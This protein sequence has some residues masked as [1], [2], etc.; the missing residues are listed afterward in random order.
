V[1]LAK[2]RFGVSWQVNRAGLEDLL[3][4]G[5]PQRA[6]RATEACTA[7]VIWT[8]LRPPSSGRRARG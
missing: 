4:E 3:D 8:S 5:D 1:R 6:K 2:D 7:C